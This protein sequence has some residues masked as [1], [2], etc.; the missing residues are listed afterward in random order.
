[1]EAIVLSLSL[2]TLMILT[3]CASPK[4]TDYVQPGPGK[5]PR[6]NTIWVYNFAATAAGIPEQ[7]ALAHRPDLETAPQTADE[8]AA[9]EALGQE[10]AA[11]LVAEIQATGMNSALATPDTQPRANDLVIRGYLLSV[12][13]GNATR[14]V[15]IGFGSGASELR[16]AV[17][18]F[19][20]TDTG[21]RKLGSAK[22][23]MGGSKSPGS[24]AGVAGLIATHNPAGLLISTGMK[25]Y[26][27]ESGNNKVEG[28][29]RTIIK[30][31]GE[32]LK[33][34]FQQQGWVK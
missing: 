19:R 9:G 2:F 15:A 29:A 10:M 6:P 25:V 13:E 8:A 1:M 27:E 32:V 34:R 18:G 11:Q 21:L 33:K 28:Q 17:E 30:K 22:V 24:V 23:D 3:G 16:I 20:M 4:V 26:G 14:R 31:M 5:I 12:E 7:S